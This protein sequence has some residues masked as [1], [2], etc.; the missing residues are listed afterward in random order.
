MFIEVGPGY[1]CITVILEALH[2]QICFYYKG[3]HGTRQRI[4]IYLLGDSFDHQVASVCVVPIVGK[5]VQLDF[6]NTQI[7]RI[8]S[9]LRTDYNRLNKYRSQLGK[10]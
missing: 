7:D 5:I 10:P 9:E 1:S 4:S 6:P 3:L 8:L 2:G